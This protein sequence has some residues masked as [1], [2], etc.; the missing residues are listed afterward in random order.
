MWQFRATK[1]S[2]KPQEHFASRID[3]MSKG[4]KV[5]PCSLDDDFASHLRV[6]RAKVRVRSR[7]AE[8]ER[9]LLVRVEHFGFEDPVCADYR[10]WN[11]VAIR[12]RYSCSYGN[13]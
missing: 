4:C 11:I 8:G 7:F 6:N 3:L 12:P 9:K 1:P 2:T 13:R 5:S 10:V